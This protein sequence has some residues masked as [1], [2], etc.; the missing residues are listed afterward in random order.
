M[1]KGELLERLKALPQDC[2]VK[3][4]LQDRGDATGMVSDIVLLAEE[5]RYYMEEFGEA[6]LQYLEQWASDWAKRQVRE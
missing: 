3:M 4:Y 6:G 5:T 1:D 2:P